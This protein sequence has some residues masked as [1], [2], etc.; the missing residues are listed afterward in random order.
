MNLYYTDTLILLIQVD[1]KKKQKTKKLSALEFQG[2]KG[3]ETCI[4][5]SDFCELKSHR[6]LIYTDVEV[7]ERTF[8]FL[9][10]FFYLNQVF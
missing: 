2:G 7:K 5:C 10:S 9:F 1:L 8:L 3:C 6:A 4:S